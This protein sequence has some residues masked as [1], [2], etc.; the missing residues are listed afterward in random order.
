MK[1]I[2]D[3]PADFEIGQTRGVVTD[4]GRRKLTWFDK[5]TLMTDDC[6]L[7]PVIA[8]SKTASSIRFI[9]DGDAAKRRGHSGTE[10][11]TIVPLDGRKAGDDPFTISSGD[12]DD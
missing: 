1:V 9:C 5:E 12:R 11:I 2:I 3:M 7:L 4:K 8:V 10:G 6:I